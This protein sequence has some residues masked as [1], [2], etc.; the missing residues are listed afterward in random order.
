MNTEKLIEAVESK[1]LTGQEGIG[2]NN[3]I[4]EAISIINQALEGYA[5]VP[6][7]PTNEMKRA[8][9]LVSSKEMEKGF[10]FDKPN[11]QYVGEVYKAMIATVKGDE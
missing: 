3:G 4:D 7:E 8:A 5:I 11:G 6:I 10:V 9:C 1:R 2:F